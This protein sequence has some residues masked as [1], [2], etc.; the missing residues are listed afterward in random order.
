MRTVMSVAP[1]VNKLLES[2]S[3][4]LTRRPVKANAEANGHVDHQGVLTF[5]DRIFES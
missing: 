2:A 1:R 3:L 5:N 4:T